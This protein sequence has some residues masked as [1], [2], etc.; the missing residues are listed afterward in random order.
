MFNL[1]LGI[2][3]RTHWRREN[4]DQKTKQCWMAITK[5]E[6]AFVKK[7]PQSSDGFLGGN[8]VKLYIIMYHQKK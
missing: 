4:G 1:F 8:S 3:A 2:G 6:V 7:Q 5:S